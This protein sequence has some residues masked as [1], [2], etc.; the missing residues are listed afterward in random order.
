MLLVLL[1]SRLALFH[2][3]QLSVLLQHLHCSSMQLR[4]IQP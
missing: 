1:V 2:A 4:I 3:R